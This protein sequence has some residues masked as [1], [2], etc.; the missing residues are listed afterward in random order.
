MRNNADS[1]SRQPCTERW[2]WCAKL[3][4][5]EPKTTRH[6]STQ[7]PP[8]AVTETPVIPSSRKEATRGSTSPNASENRSVID[9]MGSTIKIEPK[10]TIEY[11]RSA[12]R[13]IWTSSP[14]CVSKQHL[15]VNLVGKMY[16]IWVLLLR[17][18][19]HNGTNNLWIM[20]FCA[21]GGWVTTGSVFYIKL[22]YLKFFGNIP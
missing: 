16:H 6:M 12:N 8:V 21:G 5:E 9:Q 11:S 4:Q 15:K 19:G 7:T 13:M 3:I 14:S 22:Y 17:H 18:C 20:V 2:K 1:L 10:W